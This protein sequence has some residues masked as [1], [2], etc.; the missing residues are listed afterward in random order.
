MAYETIYLLEMESLRLEKSQKANATSIPR[1]DSGRTE[2]MCRNT[3][4]P[5]F[6]N[7]TNLF[8][9]V[10]TKTAELTPIEKSWD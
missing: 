6:D 1:I 7:R 2:L 8:V 5:T 10:G 4:V 3:S 9:V